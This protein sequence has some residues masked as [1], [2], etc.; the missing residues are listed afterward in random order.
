M[1]FREQAA[2]NFSANIFLRSDEQIMSTDLLAYVTPSKRHF[3]LRALTKPLYDRYYPDRSSGQHY[4]AYIG[5]SVLLLALVAMVKRWRETWIW[6]LMAILLVGLASSMVLRVNGQLFENIPT[7]YRILAPLQVA[8][9]IRVPERYVLFLALP[10][11]LLAAYGWNSLI[12]TRRLARWSPALTLLL[13]FII[14]FEYLSLPAQMQYVAYDKAVLKQLAEEPGSFAVLNLPLR[15]RFS[16]EYMFE[17]TFHERPILQGHVSREPENLYRFINDNEWFSSLPDL[18]LD[19]G[20]LMAQLNDAQVA[21][22][23]LSKI[24]LE[25]ATWQL[26]KQHIPYAPYF[27]DDRFL[28]YATAPQ[29]G[30]DLDRPIEIL[31]RL[32]TVEKNLSSFCSA[33]QIVAVTRLTWANTDSL[34][35]DYAVSLLAHSEKTGRQFAAPLTPLADSWPTSQWPANSITRHAYTLDLPVGESPYSISLLLYQQGQEEPLTT[36]IDLGQIDNSSCTVT[37]TDSSPANVLFAEKLRLLAY[38]VQQDATDLAL[39]LYWLAE[40]RPVAAYKFFVH[41]YDPQ[42]GEIV[43]QVDTMPQEWRL[44]TTVWDDG[45]LV[46]DE[47]NLSLTDVPPGEYDLAIGIYDAETGQRLPIRAAENQLTVSADGRLLL[48]YTV[49]VAEE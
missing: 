13:S 45:E 19:P 30:R 25:E 32:G 1:L 3:M 16:K 15:N 40:E 21:Y 23:L 22:V 36:L 12:T 11:S 47:I 33:D 26:W 14:L 17:Q 18:T 28:V 48:P 8:R 46:A 37:A 5:L 42:T 34:P 43:A 27:E 9:L 7:L 31:P 10:V 20:F 2:S 29:F 6:L 24:W 49:P 4:P 38:D 41:V 39:T 35:G 44:P